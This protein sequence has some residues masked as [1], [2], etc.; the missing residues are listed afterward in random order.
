MKQKMKQNEERML[1][2]LDS[3][4]LGHNAIQLQ[5][6]TILQNKGRRT[7][8]VIQRS[9]G[10]LS[11]TGSVCVWWGGRFMA[12]S[13]HVSKN[14]VAKPWDSS[15]EEV[16]R[17]HGLGGE[18]LWAWKAENQAKVNYPGTFWFHVVCFVR[19]GIHLGPIYPFLLSYVS[20]LEQDCL[21]Y[22]GLTSASWSTEPI[23]FHRFT[24]GEEFASGWI[25]PW[26]SLIGDLDLDKI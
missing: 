6:Y 19:F 16:L 21:S 9:S 2:S 26:F 5:I 10:C 13:T 15:P 24:A 25:V 7:L 1:D 23:W 17:G 8:Q 4:G 11:S 3:S 12:A 20:L 14:G 18:L 22:V